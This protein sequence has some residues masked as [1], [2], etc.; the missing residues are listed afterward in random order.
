[1]HKLDTLDG[2]TMAYPSWWFN[3]RSSNTEPLIRPIEADTK[4]C[5]DKRTTEVLQIIRDADPSMK[6]ETA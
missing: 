1:M 6:I 2:V 4:D 5:M 3:I